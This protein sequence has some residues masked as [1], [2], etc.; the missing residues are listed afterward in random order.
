MGKGVKT[1]QKKSKNGRDSQETLVISQL[2]S[3]QSGGRKRHTYNKTA[4]RLHASKPY[5]ARGHGAAAEEDKSE[6]QVPPTGS[7]IGS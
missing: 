4:T 6:N 3:W 7:D 2:A 5:L 1:Q